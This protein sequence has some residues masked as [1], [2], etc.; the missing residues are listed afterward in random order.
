MMVKLRSRWGR[1]GRSPGTSVLTEEGTR[2]HT[3]G[4]G[5]VATEAEVGV[6]G[7][8]AQDHPG[9]PAATRSWTRREGPS[10]GALGGSA[11]LTP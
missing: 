1:E 6:T 5:H 10:P 4:G 2:T 3:Q 9:L 11:A 8:L 7:P